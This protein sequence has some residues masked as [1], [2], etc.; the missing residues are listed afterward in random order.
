MALFFIATL[1]MGIAFWAI[2]E[3]QKTEPSPPIVTA[4]TARANF[5]DMALGYLK[6][7]A[8]EVTKSLPDY[9]ILEKNVPPTAFLTEYYAP[10]NNLFSIAFP[11]GMEQSISRTT[12][13]QYTKQIATISENLIFFEKAEFIKAQRGFADERQIALTIANESEKSRQLY[14]I[15]QKELHFRNTHEWKLTHWEIFDFEDTEFEFVVYFKLHGID[16]SFLQ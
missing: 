16:W 9:F 14:E 15:A 10:K 1:G 7:Y 11:K 13:R 12:G 8:S 5:Q 2:S 3:A 4:E 6:K